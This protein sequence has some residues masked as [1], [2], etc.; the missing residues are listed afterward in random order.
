MTWMA[1]YLGVEINT[2]F[3]GYLGDT[4][5]LAV[6][7]IFFAV[8]AN[9]W[10]IGSGISHVVR[11]DVCIKLGEGLPLIA[12]KYACFGII[13]TFVYSCVFGMVIMYFCEWI[14]G[15]MSQVDEIL[16]DLVPIIFI[17]GIGGFFNG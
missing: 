11:T 17:A 3:I 2:I 12:K 4:N 13:L 16:V 9:S 5:K 7:V 6:W 8:F 14:A 15:F 10:I 1:S